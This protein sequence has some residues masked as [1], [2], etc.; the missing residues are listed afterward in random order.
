MFAHGHFKSLGSD[1]VLQ[2]L[3][4]PTYNVLEKQASFVL[5]KQASFP[6]SQKLHS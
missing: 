1:S 6:D 3:T 5:E 4:M 2:A